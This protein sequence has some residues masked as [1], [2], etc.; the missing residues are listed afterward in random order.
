MFLYHRRFDPIPKTMMKKIFFLICLLTLSNVTYASPFYTPSFRFLPAK[1]LQVGLKEVYTRENDFGLENVS[2]RSDV[3]ADL[4]YGISKN[5]ELDLSLPYAS[6]GTNKQSGLR[7]SLVYLKY[8]IYSSRNYLLADRDLD[9]ELQLGYKT[10]TGKEEK[11]LGSRDTEILY[12]FLGRYEIGTLKG[13]DY[14]FYFHLGLWAPLEG[15]YTYKNIFQYDFAVE[16]PANKK[17]SLFLEGNGNRTSD[18][19]IV[20]IGPGI[21]FHPKEDWEINFSVEGSISDKGGF[22]NSRSGIGVIHVF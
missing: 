4:Y 14:F 11:G 5:F 20:Y 17:I 13:K 19:D 21:Q 10:E 6:G 3:T 15:Y 12:S 18:Y 7:D 22:L 16:Y 9:I 1:K 2:W 8:R